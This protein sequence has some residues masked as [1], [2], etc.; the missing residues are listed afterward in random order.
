MVISA[1][2]VAASGVSA[3]FD[4][5]AMSAGNVA[6]A[7]DTSS[8]AAGAYRAQTPVLTPVPAGAGQGDGVAVSQVALGPPGSPVYAP[9]RPTV[10]SR[11]VTFTPTVSLANQLVQGDAA[12]LSVEAN[13]A[14]L[15]RAL[16]AYRS[17]LDVG[18][19]PGSTVS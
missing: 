5:L 9:G 14:V 18:R 16:S 2:N 3:G 12:S 19:H 8:T 4:W 11:G 13:A 17:L 10:N 6:N 1:L 15:R 7:N